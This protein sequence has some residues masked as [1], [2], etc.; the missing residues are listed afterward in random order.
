MLDNGDNIIFIIIS[1]VSFYF[2][3]LLLS[4]CESYFSHVEMTCSYGEENEQ[5]E[6]LL[7]S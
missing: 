1:K 3:L 5:K 4:N 7:L 2:K 6:T